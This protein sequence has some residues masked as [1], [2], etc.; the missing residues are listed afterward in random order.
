MAEKDLTNYSMSDLAQKNNIS[1]L[2]KKIEALLFVASSPVPVNQL[3]QTLG[4]SSHEV[5]I[6][7]RNLE[8]YYEINSGLRIQTHSGRMQL[9]TAAELGPLIEKFLGLEA[10]TRLS[11]AALEALAIIAYRQ[12]ITRP[13]IDSVRGVNSDGVIKSLLNRGLLEEVGRLEGPGRPILYGTTPEFLQQFG[14]SSIKELPLFEREEQ[15]LE[16][17]QLLKD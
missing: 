3:T 8:K 2:E 10:T 17:P 9:T 5:E 7:I 12:P 15:K 13:G 14:L 6:G 16:E 1:D 4:I 11:K